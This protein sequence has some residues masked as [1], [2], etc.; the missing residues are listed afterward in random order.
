MSKRNT[1]IGT[2]FWMAPEVLQQT[3]YDVKSDIWSL[4]ITLIELAEGRPPHHDVHPLRAIF[5]IPSCDPPTLTHP[6]EAAPEFVDFLQLCLQ[7]DASR[8][9]A[10]KE[11]LQV[12]VPMQQ[13]HAMT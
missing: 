9:P 3:D 13:Y 8:R 4:G 7:K 5:L 1:L 12:C 10:A 6:D 11:L 2:P